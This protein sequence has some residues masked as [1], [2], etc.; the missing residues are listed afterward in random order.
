MARQVTTVVI[1]SYRYVLSKIL[2]YLF[3]KLK[4]GSKEQLIGMNYVVM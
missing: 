3:D 4:I 1:K 2:D